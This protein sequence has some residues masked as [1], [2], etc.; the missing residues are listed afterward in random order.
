MSSSYAFCTEWFY[1]MYLQILSVPMNSARFGWTLFQFKKK[2]TEIENHLF[3]LSHGAHSNVKS[4]LL[5]RTGRKFAQN[6]VLVGSLDVHIAAAPY[7]AV[8][9]IQPDRC[10]RPLVVWG[11]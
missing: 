4:T 11:K 1:S 6:R 3:P 9:W 8:K 2:K 7:G 10:R 5:H